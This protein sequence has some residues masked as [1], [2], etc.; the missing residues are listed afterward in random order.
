MY[1]LVQF[2]P[3]CLRVT[4]R[5]KSDISQTRS[6]EIALQC[7][8]MKCDHKGQNSAVHMNAGLEKHQQA[9]EERKIHAVASTDP[10]DSA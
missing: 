7:K 1:N 5:L 9:A 8:S 10:T 6:L 3:H 4:I 2:S